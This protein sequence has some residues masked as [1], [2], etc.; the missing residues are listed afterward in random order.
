[1][2]ADKGEVRLSSWLILRYRS[3]IRLEELKE[4]TLTLCVFG[5]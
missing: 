5:R 4:T 1:M 3:D 2:D